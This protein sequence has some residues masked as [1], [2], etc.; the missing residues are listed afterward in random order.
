MGKKSDTYGP[1]C[2]RE[3][4]FEFDFR[5]GS[6]CAQRTH[7][8]S[9]A[10]HCLTFWFSLRIQLL[11]HNTLLTPYVSPVHYCF[12]SF[13]LS[14]G[15]YGICFGIIFGYDYGIETTKMTFDFV[16]YWMIFHRKWNDI[17]ILLFTSIATR[18]WH[19]RMDW[20]P[21]I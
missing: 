21:R 5:V 13:L 3:T 18:I 9:A 4:L 7:H 15:V 16:H 6:L 14:V 8:R 2:M 11:P 20:S 19:H 1:N 10:A 12:L 17:V